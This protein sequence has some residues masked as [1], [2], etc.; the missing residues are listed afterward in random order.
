[1]DQRFRRARGYCAPAV[2]AHALGGI[3]ALTDS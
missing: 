1:M 2:A 3:A